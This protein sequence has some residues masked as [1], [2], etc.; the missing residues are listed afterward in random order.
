VEGWWAKKKEEAQEEREREEEAAKEIPNG[1]EGDEWA[2]GQELK[3][4]LL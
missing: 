2:P 1:A 4:Y 3:G